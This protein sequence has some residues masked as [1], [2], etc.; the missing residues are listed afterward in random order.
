MLLACTAN[1]EQNDI[2]IMSAA[3]ADY[4]PVTVAGQKI[5]KKDTNLNI[6]L[7]KT[8]DILATLGQA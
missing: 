4:T 2:I 7:K 1:F 3:V 5:K 6:E 8:T